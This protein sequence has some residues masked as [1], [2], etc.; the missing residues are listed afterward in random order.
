VIPESGAPRLL[1][2][3]D[4]PGFARLV[5]RGLGRLGFE[6]VHAP[7]GARGLELLAN[8]AFDVVALDHFMP[9]LSSEQTL[10]RILAM[11]SP[12]PVVYVTACDE[13]LVAVPALK[14]GAAD[15]VLKDAGES[16]SELLAAVLEQAIEN[17]RLKAA[18]DKAHAEIS[19][20]RERAEIMLK[21]VNHRVANS[22]TM[23]VSMAHLQ[24][25]S[26][27]EGSARDAVAA[28][29]KRVNAIAQVHKRLYTS[30]DVRVVALDIYL[31][32]LVHNLHDSISDAQ[33]ITDIVLD[34]CP[35][36]IGTDQAISVGVILSEM[37][38]NAGKYAYVGE[39]KGVVR[40]RLSLDEPNA[41]ACLTVEDDGVGSAGEAPS[42]TGLGG[43]I[44]EALAH[45]LG[46][47]LAISAGQS[48]TRARLRFPV[49]LESERRLESQ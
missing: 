41:E 22:L 15:Y 45:G 49:E 26:L 37:I 10:E 38:T 36:K 47:E 9:G 24:A 21:E 13:S 11:P 42:G 43:Q 23:V 6:V 46:G 39:N 3:D 14:A 34:C 12:P 29:A 30:E 8:E 44:M 4:D 48:G 31:A 40:V 17:S 27:P 28:F 5:T 33:T 16:F 35:L 32:E 19:A 20:A 25:S 1:Y 2:I 7:D 18:Q